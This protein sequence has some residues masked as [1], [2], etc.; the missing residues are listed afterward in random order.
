MERR[1][2][3]YEQSNNSPE[4]ARKS[5]LPLAKT[6]EKLGDLSSAIRTLENSY[7]YG[8]K[9]QWKDDVAVQLGNYY[10]K[11]G[12][13]YAALDWYEKSPNPG[14][15]NKVRTAEVY[16]R[17]GDTQSAIKYYEESIK[18]K[19]NDVYNPMITLG[20]IYSQNGNNSK[21]KEMYNRLNNKKHI[22]LSET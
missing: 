4:S 12:D 11:T 5:A 10:S 1:V 2:D 14:F 3:Y 7:D 21:A 8:K 19:R 13:D 6:Y 22:C 16:Q 9:K 18:S 15:I 17:L 20:L